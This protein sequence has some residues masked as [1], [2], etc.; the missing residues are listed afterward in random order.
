MH[1]LAGLSCVD[2]N[3][4]ESIRLMSDVVYWSNIPSDAEYKSPLYDLSKEK[5]LTFE[6]DHGGWNNIQI[7]METVLVVAV[8]MGRTLVLPPDAGMYL[9]QKHSPF[10]QKQKEK[11]ISHNFHSKIFSSRHDT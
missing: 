3:G 11:I 4:P 5:Y 10:P 8:P 9:L 6:P 1:E 2:H 7:N